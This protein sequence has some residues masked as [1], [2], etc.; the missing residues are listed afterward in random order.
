MVFNLFQLANLVSREVVRES[1]TE[2]QASVLSYF[3]QTAKVRIKCGC[4]CVFI[5]A[6]VTC[7]HSSFYQ[8]RICMILYSTFNYSLVLA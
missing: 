7:N 5:C 1:I 6:C 2:D 4:V 8:V 3:I